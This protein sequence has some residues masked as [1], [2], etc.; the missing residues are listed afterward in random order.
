MYDLPGSEDGCGV[1]GRSRLHD[2]EVKLL[3]EKVRSFQPQLLLSWASGAVSSLCRGTSAPL[4]IDSRLRAL[5]PS[6][7]RLE[8]DAALYANGTTDDVRREFQRWRERAAM[9]ETQLS[10]V[11][12]VHAAREAALREA[13]RQHERASEAAEARIGELTTERADLRSRLHGFRSALS[14]LKL[15]CGTLRRGLQETK[16]EVVN[17][18]A[19]DMSALW[20]HAAEVAAYWQ[21][22]VESLERSRGSKEVPEL[23]ADR[24]RLR[25]QLRAETERAAAAQRDADGLR[26]DLHKAG[27]PGGAAAGGGRAGE[28]EGRVR[29]LEAELAAA[30]RGE[31]GEA[32]EAAR[33]EAARLRALLEEAE[34]AA[35]RARG[36][37]GDDREKLARLQR[38]A[39]GLTEQLG[40][41]Q[42]EL[43]AAQEQLQQ[44]RAAKGSK[45]LVERLAA[46]E[47]ALEA[48]RGRGREA[49]ARGRERLQEAEAE[50]QARAAKIAALNAE[51]G[52]RNR[53]HNG[54][55]T[56]LQE[57]FMKKLADV[58]SLHR[59][60]VG[61]AEAKLRDELRRERDEAERRLQ[62]ATTG[63]WRRRSGTG[64]RRRGCRRSSPTSAPRGPPPSRRR[65]RRGASWRR[66]GGCGGGGGAAGALE[67]A[68]AGAGAGQAEAAAR[69]VQGLE[70]HLARLSELVRRKDA[71]IQALQ[72]TVH[73]DPRPPGP[74]PGPGPGPEARPAS[75]AGG[76]AKPASP[77]AE[78]EA[79]YRELRASAAGGVKLPP[80]RPAALPRTA[81]QSRRG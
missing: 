56:D 6:V 69:A 18:G 5:P 80:V 22:R 77:E 40:R 81:S 27:G 17:M 28:L 19:I 70:V 46:A 64:S 29:A 75:G 33:K 7:L 71:E 55:L 67:E 68:R 20:G 54:Q 73:N 44:L 2:Q 32:A 37:A 43:R 41:A 65:R 11:E 16:V 57:S 58:D 66:R 63:R 51:I 1:C 53:A 74:S 12:E 52:Q 42:K 60:E 26:I 3:Q 21:G 76:G 47:A 45:E 39:A 25:K 13:V 35:G 14:R 36:Q 61:E 30:R 59:A 23:L 15:E 24:E 10:S 72:M 48:E 38:E 78:A 31:A 62:L 49:E 34:A 79:A 9:L 8:E 4:S 50:L